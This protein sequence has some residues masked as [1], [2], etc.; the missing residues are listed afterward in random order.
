MGGAIGL[1]QR[2]IKCSLAFPG[3]AWNIYLSEFPAVVR[4]EG[5]G[6]RHS[7]TD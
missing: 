2:R 7:L 1:F 6:G 4:G 3:L 5:G